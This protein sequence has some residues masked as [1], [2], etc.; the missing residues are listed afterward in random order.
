MGEEKTKRL[1]GL[2]LA[3]SNLKLHSKLFGPAAC[4]FFLLRKKY[5]SIH[6]KQHSA[7]A[8]MDDNVPQTC[9]CTGNPELVAASRAFFKEARTVLAKNQLFEKWRI[10]GTK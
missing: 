1:P 4:F 9:S 7:H 8:N 5:R 6:G 3:S 10:L 2:E